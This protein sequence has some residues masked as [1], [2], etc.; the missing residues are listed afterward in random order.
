MRKHVHY[1]KLFFNFE[2]MWPRRALLLGSA[3]LLT[4][5]AAATYLGL[6]RRRARLLASSHAPLLVMS[7]GTW[8][9]T[10][11]NLGV[12]AG[13][14]FAAP[15]D[16]LFSNPRMVAHVISTGGAALLDA[17]EYFQPAVDS[18]T[19]CHR[20]YTPMLAATTK[21]GGK[22]K[23]GV[24]FSHH[25]PT[26]AEDHAYLCRTVR[27]LVAALASPQ[28]KLCA[29]V[30][31]TKSEAIDDADLEHLHATIERH[32]NPLGRVTLVVVRLTT[33][34]TQ[35]SGG[36]GSRGGSGDGSGGGSGGGSGT[37]GLAAA[38]QRETTRGHTTMRVVEMT[39]R[40]GLCGQGLAL[41]NADDRRE[42]L[43]ALFGAEAAFAGSRADI[44]TWPRL[45]PDPLKPVAVPTA[46]DGAAGGP[47]K[48][49]DVSEVVR[50][51]LRSW[52]KSHG[53]GEQKHAKDGYMISRVASLAPGSAASSRK[54]Y[55]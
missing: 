29:L 36:D 39:C 27:R 46:E 26:R 47:R 55:S 9:F 33:T 3:L 48:A 49:G 16:W 35:R 32:S 7:F 10:A 50:K 28:P 18:R 54:V 12:A 45:A 51:E 20:T 19:F 38:R 37:V 13:R 25:D 4:S 40:D 53:S 1:A 22:N 31:M 6:L 15:F 17:D 41:R 8:C 14:T 44:L 43:V 5:A 2:L 42:L 30:S 23:H 21:K 34:T 11:T 24:V 52:C